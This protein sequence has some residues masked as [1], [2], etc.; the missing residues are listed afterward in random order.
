MAGSILAIIAPIVT[1]VIKLLV[2]N[3]ERKMQLIEQFNAF[4]AMHANDGQESVDHVK[5]VEDQ[6]NDLK[7]ETDDISKGR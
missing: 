6:I 1:W 2:S 7:G 3:Q 4:V 5:S